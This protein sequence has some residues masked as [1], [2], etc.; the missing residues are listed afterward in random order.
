MT[1]GEREFQRLVGGLDYPL[2]IVT[3]AAAGERAGCLVGF[4]TQCSIRP[5]RYWMCLSKKNR[6]YDVARRADAMAVHLPRADDVELARLFGEETG[7]EVDKFARCEWEPGPDGT[8]P[9]LSGCSR[10]FLGRIVDRLDTGDHVS[11]LLEPVAAAAGERGQPSLG[12]QAAKALEP[13]HD[14]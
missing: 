9:L 13:G 4:G 5:P 7:D 2:Y 12:F 3:V 10:W 14:P 1:D 6:S 11:F 8:T